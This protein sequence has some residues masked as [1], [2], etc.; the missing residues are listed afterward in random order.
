MM[1]ILEVLPDLLVLGLHTGAKFGLYA[2]TMKLSE[3]TDL[4]T[5]QMYA[6]ATMAAVG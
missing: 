4:R 1:G 3:F 6:L 2:R 5:T